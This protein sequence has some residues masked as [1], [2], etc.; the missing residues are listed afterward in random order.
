MNLLFGLLFGLSVGGAMRLPGAEFIIAANA[1]NLSVM[2]AIWL[3]IAI[4]VG[5]SRSHLIQETAAATLTFVIAA[6]VFQSSPLWLYVGFF[7]QTIWSALHIG[8]RYGARAIAWYP[9]FAAMA[10]LGFIAAL[11]VVWNIL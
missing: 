1:I 11:Y 5:Q 7:G 3:G 8:N 4:G 10:N 6:L 9:G 2:A